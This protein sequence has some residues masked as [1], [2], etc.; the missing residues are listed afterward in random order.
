MGP[1][2][3][4][5]EIA[6]RRVAVIGLGRF[7][8][9]VTRALHELRYEVTAIDIDDRRVAE[10][11]AYATL[12]TCGDG[13]DEEVLRSLQV[14]RSTIAVVA[15]GS[16]LE[17]S[18]LAT[19]ALKRLGVPWVVAKATNDAHGEVLARVGADRV[20]FPERDAG[21]RLAHTLGVP[22]VDDYISL[23]S[24]SGVA[25]FLVG[26][27][28]VGRTIASAHAACGAPALAVVAVRRGRQVLTS[29]ALDERIEAGDELVVIGAD[30]AIEVF[31]D[32]GGIAE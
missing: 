3:V 5:R 24:T 16:H 1:V 6:E 23:S 19:L 32:V 31:V 4:G 28:L 2:R 13:T 8:R 14:E 17:T 7:G 27:N 9:S 20:I 11:A 29:P 21:I 25:K 30:P 26:P 15:Q 22:R 10:V 12:A 18:V